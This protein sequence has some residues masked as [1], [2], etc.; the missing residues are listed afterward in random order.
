[1]S[2]IVKINLFLLLSMMSFFAFGGKDGDE[3]FDYS[4]T[5]R[6]HQ[7]ACVGDLGKIRA[8]LEA[9]DYINGF[10]IGELDF[11][12]HGKAPHL[13]V[14]YALQERRSAEGEPLYRPFDTRIW[15]DGLTPLHVAGIYGVPAT[16][17]FLC[18]QPGINVNRPTEGL[19]EEV[20]PLRC[21]IGRPAI[22]KILLRAGA[23]V[24]E[25]DLI[26]AV[27]R[28]DLRSLEM[29]ISHFKATHPEYDFNTIETKKGSLASFAV[30]QASRDVSTLT[31]EVRRRNEDIG[32]I[33]MLLLDN[34]VNI[35]APDK[36]GGTVLHHLLASKN[37][38]VIKWVL[39][40][41]CCM[42]VLNQ[43]ESHG[44]TPLMVAA[45]SNLEEGIISQLMAMGADTR[46]L[47]MD[48]HSVVWHARQ[49]R[50]PAIVD[51]LEG[52]EH[53]CPI[54][55]GEVDH[56]V[57]PCEHKTCKACIDDWM[58]ISMTCPVCQMPITGSAPL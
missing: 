6:L 19:R 38:P 37:I 24:K 58:D 49:R 44:F 9:G 31:K 1:M 42:P 40:T 15:C 34:G 20:T 57:L 46:A 43:P 33:V 45:K 16:V 5:T 32:H 28:V 50:Y 48:G 47:D 12:G 30:S 53:E 22:V 2:K 26:L 56:K 54:C 52:R 27:E 8:Y 14:L 51:A 41:H 10:G 17:T 55:F 21:A 25:E 3:P 4:G 39:D 29:L 36:Y 23:I 11:E 13:D 7:A 35:A 18:E